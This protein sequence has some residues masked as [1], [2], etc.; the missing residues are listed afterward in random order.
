[1]CHEAKAETLSEGFHLRHRSHL[2]ARAPQHDHMRV[3]D[4]HAP[5]NTTHVRQSVGE[6]DFASRIAETLDTSER[7]AGANSD[8]TAEAVCALYFLPPTSTS[9]GEVSCC[10]STPG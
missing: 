9:C 2:A 8:S 1:M 5:G 3:V 4:H 6:K 7:T 10:I